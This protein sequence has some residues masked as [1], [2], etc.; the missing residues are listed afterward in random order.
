VEEALRPESQTCETQ[1]PRRRGTADGG[2][3]LKRE[4]LPS[5]LPAMRWQWPPRLVFG[6]MLLY[7]LVAGLIGLRSTALRL[8]MK[9][10]TAGLTTEALRA[11]VFGQAY[12]ASIRQI[13]R[14]IPEDEPYLLSTTGDLGSLL[15]VRFDLLPRRAVLLKPP[16][17]PGAPDRDCW[18]D[19]IR[20]QVTATGAYRPP[21]L[22]ERPVRVPAGCP[23][24]PWNRRAP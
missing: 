17:P 10:R 23:A 9:V 7:L 16:R 11:R 5:I 13:R 15:W 3:A 8:G 24:Q 20:W 2:R 18:Q 14:T 12:T 21:M 1:P 4:V 19:Q 6:L 22:E